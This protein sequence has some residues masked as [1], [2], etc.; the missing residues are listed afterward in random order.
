MKRILQMA[1]KWKFCIILLVSLWIVSSLITAYQNAHMTAIEQAERILNTWYIRG[2]VSMT[3]WEYK[4][5]LR[6][7]EKKDGD[8]SKDIVALKTNLATFYMEKKQY[9]KA[10]ICLREAEE[11]S[12]QTG[13]KEWPVNDLYRAYGQYETSQRNYDKALEYYEKSVKWC[14]ELY[15]SNST[16]GG[17]LYLLMSYTYLEMDDLEEAEKYAEL[18][19]MP[20]YRERDRL[21]VI[22]ALV[23]SGDIRIRQEK[24]DLAISR[25]ED[26]YQYY[27]DKLLSNTKEDADIM[28]A[29]REKIEETKRMMREGDGD[30][31]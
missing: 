9:E 21:Y 29:I 23:A 7:T 31:M 3:I 26:A 1:K 30:G 12:N 10:E 6:R 4:K 15:G 27:K 2:N 8:Q 25:Y 18:A 14:K 17:I 19:M 22:N 28:D 11:I 13:L 20:S 5:L 16:Q 24:Y